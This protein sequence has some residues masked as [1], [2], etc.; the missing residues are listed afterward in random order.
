MEAASYPNATNRLARRECSPTGSVHR[1]TAAA[2]TCLASSSSTVALQTAESIAGVR[3]GDGLERLFRL[4]APGWLTLLAGIVG[5]HFDDAE[6]GHVKVVAGIGRVRFRRLDE[7]VDEGA[8]NPLL[9]V[10][11]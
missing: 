9:L 4:P 3:V 5:E 8:V 6:A 2:A 11:V 7:R 10:E 1:S